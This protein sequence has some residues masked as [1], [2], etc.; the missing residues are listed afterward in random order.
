MKRKFLTYFTALGAM[1]CLLF[2]CGIDATDEPETAVRTI[3]YRAFVRGG[4][5]KATLNESTQY[6]FESGDRL[7]V[8]SKEGNEVKMYGILT[9]ISG[10]G[11]ATAEFQGDLACVDDFTPAAD[12]PVDV[13]LLG[14]SDVVHNI[15]SD[16]KEVTTSYT[17]G[18][19]ASN[20]AGAVQKFSDFTA[21]GTFGDASFSL[22]QQSS[23]LVFNI[24][25][26]GSEAPV[27][28]EITSKLFNNTSDL[29]RTVEVTVTEAGYVS[30]A[31][32]F[33]GGDVSLENA[34]LRLDWTD[35]ES[36]DQSTEF[37]DVSNQTLAANHYYTVSR[38]TL[39]FDG[40][41]IKAKYAN[42]RVTFK[43]RDGSVEFSEDHGG[44]W[45][46]Y[47]GREFALQS[48]GDEICFRG[49]RTNCDCNGTTQLFW[50]DKVCYIAGKITS[51]LADQNSLATN[52]FRSAFS[53]GN[54]NNTKPAAVTFVD[55]DPSDPLILPAFTADNCY[56]EMFRACTSLTFVPDL[57]A[58]VVAPNCYFNM[59]RSCT[60]LTRA[61]IV[62]P[63]TTMTENCY[64][65]LFRQ[66]EN[67]ISVPI[68]HAATLAPSCYQQMLS[69][70]WALRTVVCLATD[71]SATDCTKDWL[72]SVTNTNECTFWKA[73][74]MTAWQRDYS[75]I[76]S[77]WDVQDYRE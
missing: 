52:A 44:T 68:F 7:H 2:S 10:A 73:S 32:A 21:T 67:L 40:F 1:L 72:S 17:D 34:K 42:T 18:Q 3:P 43:Y 6:V 25:M 55:I 31:L 47:D 54:S 45:S 60:G 16:Y 26:R 41:R 75:G 30:F 36:V 38:S 57:P 22:S 23:F 59:F 70:C 4:Q 66:C 46:T 24:R 39:H 77:N 50:A 8:C 13:T 28:R 20:F 15:S 76:P 14:A 61:D 5:T 35:S 56:R 53:N 71:I 27:G 33:K 12:T 29:L 51:L 64:R 9:L 63:A 48:A 65:E 58:T 62:L 19:F 74:S 11:E 37:D 49:N 69:G